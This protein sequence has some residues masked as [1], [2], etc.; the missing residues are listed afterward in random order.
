MDG[1]AADMFSPMD[2]S[3]SMRSRV[4]QIS[5]QDSPGNPSIKK[6][7]TV[8]SY[9]LHKRAACRICSKVV[10]LCIK[11]NILC[12]PDSAPE[13]CTLTLC[14]SLYK[15]ISP[16]CQIINPYG[17]RPWNVYAAYDFQY[18]RSFREKMV[19]RES[20][21]AQIEPG[22]Q[23]FDLLN[24]PGRCL[25]AKGAPVESQVVTISASP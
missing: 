4:R 5:F 24:N 3:S 6:N 10:S 11:S 15:C 1:G 8:I 17:S 20:D 7:A 21:G 22:F 2:S 12:E 9:S 14:Y 13:Q 16:S 19:I 25:A 23:V 18:P